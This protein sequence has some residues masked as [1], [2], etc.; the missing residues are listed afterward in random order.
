MSNDIGFIGLGVLGNAIARNIVAS[1]ASVLGYDRDAAAQY[2][3]VADG[4]TPATDVAAV[5]AQCDVVFTCLPHGSAVR[6]VVAQIAEVSNPGQIIVELSTLSISDKDA[7]RAALVQTGRRVLDC[8]VSGNRIM[9]LAKGLTAFCSGDRSDYEAVRDILLT[10]CRK[11]H[12]VGAFGN[13]SKTKF[14]GNI[15]NL[16]HNTVAAEAMVLAIKSGLDPQMF[17]SVISGSGSSSGMFEVRGKLMADN[18]YA[19]EGMNFSVPLKDSQIIADHAASVG[20]PIPLYQAA[21]QFYHAAAAQGLAHLDAAAVCR[22]ME[23]NAQCE[24]PA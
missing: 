12:Y 13:G 10:F 22:V 14:C 1:G 18:D 11:E 15:L 3:A 7:A 8:P 21:L 17:H 23:R 4:V 19:V 6:A 16:V 9:A 20:T 2:A 24:R 5:A